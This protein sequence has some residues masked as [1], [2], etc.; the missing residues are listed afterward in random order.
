VSGVKLCKNAWL[1]ADKYQFIFTRLIGKSD[2]AYQT[3]I[4]RAKKAGRSLDTVKKFIIKETYPY[5]I[6]RALE[7]AL[8]YSLMDSALLQ[9]D[10]AIETSSNEGKKPVGAQKIEKLMALVEKAKDDIINTFKGNLAAFTKEAL[11]MQ[12][13][14]EKLK[15]QV[16]QLKARL[17]G[18][19]VDVED[20]D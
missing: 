20:D 5:S 6:E 2:K 11:M 18:N 16:A 8:E 12:E 19:L 10:E 13:E 3:D 1:K 17:K 4:K 15:E 7:C 14:N 9:E